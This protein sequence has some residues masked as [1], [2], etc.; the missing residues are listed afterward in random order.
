MPCR[1]KP[2]WSQPTLRTCFEEGANLRDSVNAEHTRSAEQPLVA[3]LFNLETLVQQPCCQTARALSE[4]LFG[5]T[6]RPPFQSS[7][8]CRI[9][10][11]SVL[12]D[13]TSDLPVREG[14][15]W[16]QC[17]DGAKSGPGNTCTP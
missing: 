5:A 2:R 17:P 6:A 8:D 13:G 15:A 10:S 1:R 14:S 9:Q 3:L 12:R 11:V 7:K 16:C 4:V